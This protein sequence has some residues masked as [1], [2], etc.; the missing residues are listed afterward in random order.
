[1]YNLDLK[2]IHNEIK[3][4]ISGKDY[5]K[6]YREDIFQEAVLIRLERMISPK[7]AVIKAINKYKYQARPIRRPKHLDISTVDIPVKEAQPSLVYRHQ[8]SERQQRRLFEKFD[9]VL[10][11]EAVLEDYG[12]RFNTLNSTN[13]NYDLAIQL[14]EPCPLC[15][16]KGCFTVFETN[17]HI[18]Y[19]C[20]TLPKEEYYSKYPNNI[21]SVFI[22]LTGYSKEEVRDKIYRNL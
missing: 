9:D 16:C 12:Y 13:G 3:N 5:L 4:Q 17:S 19:Y 20:F 18:T 11:V 6:Q 10:K 15:G 21:T 8:L 7:K 22:L 1:M 14:V 2:E